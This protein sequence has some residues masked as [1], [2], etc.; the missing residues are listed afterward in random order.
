MNL[1]PYQNEAIEGIQKKFREGKRSIALVLTCGAGKTVIA[2]RMIQMAVQN[3]KR[4]LFLAHRT[5]LI[6]QCR[7]KL[8]K[9]GVPA[10]IIKSGF[11]EDRTQ[12]VQIASIQTIRN[13][14]LPIADIIIIDECHNALSKEYLKVIDQYKKNKSFF[15]GLTASPFRTKKTEGLDLIFE[16]YV[17]PINVQ[18]MVDK[19]YICE[20]KVFLAK[21]FID[22]S[23]V[24]KSKGDFDISELSKLF[25]TNDAYKNFIDAYHT[26]IGNKKTIIFCVNKHHCKNA[27]EALIKEGYKGN[28][29]TES[30]SE[31]DRR[32]FLGLLENGTYDYVINCFV[33]GEG[34]DIPS[35][36]AIVLLYDTISRIKYMQTANRGCRILPE[37]ECVP[38]EKRKKKF[39]TVLDM[40]GNTMRFGH[41]EQPFE[42]SLAPKSTKEKSGVAP[43]KACTSCGFMMAVQLRKCP[44][45]GLEMEVKKTKAEIEQE[46]FVE[47]DKRKMEVQKYLSYGKDKWHL[48]PSDM[49]V[50]YAKAKGF[51]Q[52][53]GWSNHVLLERGEGVKKVVIR[54]YDEPDY[55]KWCGWLRKAYFSKHKLPIDAHTWQFIEETKKEVIFEYK[56][57]EKEAIL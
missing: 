2:S 16:D 47:L 40:A 53:K 52:P 48:I 31:S 25:D 18:Q 36:T 21:K 46:T 1:R 5:F 19:G 33:L 11:K 4:I 43:I 26:H 12:K 28:Y 42:I 6:T 44:E 13:R 8:L 34:L 56:L 22:T 7:D 14:P 15:I 38:F 20:S 49:L 23:N 41:L 29:I 32:L 51:P 9:F 17:S 10:G 30:T 55:Y 27:H 24:A 54:N 3:K 50:E 37:E 57:K 35:V 45:C 39:F